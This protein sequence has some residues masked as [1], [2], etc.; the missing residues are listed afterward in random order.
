MARK[1]IT[2]ALKRPFEGG[3]GLIRNIVLQEPTAGDY[4]QLGAPQTWVRASGGMALVENDQ[5]IR[6]YA[7]RSIIDPD[8]LLAMTNMSVIDAIAVKDAI[9]GFF[10][11]EKATQS[12]QSAIS[13]SSSSESLT[14][15]PA[16]N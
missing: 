7:E 9:V 6:A 11:E 1:Q 4:F 15:S 10:T 14:Q 13:S 3:K 12:Q 5:A 8:P 16:A 2:V